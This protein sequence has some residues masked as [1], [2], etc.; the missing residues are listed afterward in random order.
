VLA[1]ETVWGLACAENSFTCRRAGRGLVGCVVRASLARQLL[2]LQTSWQGSCGRVVRAGLAR[3]TAS[4]ARR[5]GR[6]LGRMGKS[7]FWWRSIAICGTSPVIAWTRGVS[8][9]TARTAQDVPRSA[10]SDDQR[11][12]PGR[13]VPTRRPQH[14]HFLDAFLVAQAE[15][16]L[17]LV[18]AWYP[19]PAV[20]CRPS[21]APR[22]SAAPWCRSHRGNSLC[23]KI[24]SPQN[25][26]R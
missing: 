4:P 25:A 1:G 6:G 12:D 8:S 22:R 19:S 14:L 7:L 16:Q 2:H 20:N 13:F 9:Q 11:G 21:S 10:G 23:H 24:G 5:T 17:P 26:R 15:D 18:L 3:Q